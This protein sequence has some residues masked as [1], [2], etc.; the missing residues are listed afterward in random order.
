MKPQACRRIQ[1]AIDVMDRVE[2]PQEWRGVVQPMPE[3]QRVVEQQEAENDPQRLRQWQLAQQPHPAALSQM[4]GGRYQRHLAR[5]RGRAGQHA[6][7]HIASEALDARLSLPPQ[8]PPTLGDE[9]CP[10]RHAKR[11][12][13]PATLRHRITRTSNLCST[14]HLAPSTLAPDALSRV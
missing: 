10:K 11:D 9:Q 13:P 1:I 2:A 6:E 14:R 5:R 3:I 12:P 7:R 8:R 4:L